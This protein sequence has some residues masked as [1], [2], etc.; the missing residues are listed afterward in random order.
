MLSGLA[1]PQASSQRRAC[2][3]TL[4][5]SAPTRQGSSCK[6]CWKA[7]SRK[8]RAHALRPARRVM[9]LR[10]GNFPT[11]RFHER[12][13]RS[14]TSG[15]H[16]VAD[17]GLP[18]AAPGPG[19]GVA[20]PPAPQAHRCRCLAVVTAADARATL[21]PAPAGHQRAAPEAATTPTPAGGTRSDRA[22]LP[23]VRSSS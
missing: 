15:H 21:A 6:G 9:P 4:I 19:M 17:A 22:A 1:S 16:F 8:K 23:G 14:R 10:S 13:H 12:A 7:L 2:S 18:T 20:L 5:S 3:R 11:A